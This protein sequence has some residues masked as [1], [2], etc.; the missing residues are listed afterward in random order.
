M[1]A[2]AVPSFRRMRAELLVET[3]VAP[4]IEEKEILVT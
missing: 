2:F 3:Y 1:D 4:F